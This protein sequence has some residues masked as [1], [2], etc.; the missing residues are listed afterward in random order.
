MG[1]RNWSNGLS[2]LFRAEVQIPSVVR[3][4]G[5]SGPTAEL[6]S[7]P[8]LQP[9]GSTLPKMMS[10]PGNSISLTSGQGGGTQ[11]S[12]LERLC[13]VIPE[14]QLVTSIEIS[15]ANTM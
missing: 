6:L 3:R 12:F 10:L 4:D 9:K 13:K 8:H 5:C 2:D 15:T 1:V 11:A 14:Q 7:E